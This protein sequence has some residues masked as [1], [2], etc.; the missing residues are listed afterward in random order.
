MTRLTVAKQSPL[1]AVL[2]TAVQ[3]ACVLNG[4]LLYRVVSLTPFD[5]LIG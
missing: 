3:C 5:H 4:L 1:C 2:G